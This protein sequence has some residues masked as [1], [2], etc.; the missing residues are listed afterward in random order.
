MI[1][2]L[3]LFT[4]CTF[5]HLHHGPKEDKTQQNKQVHFIIIIWY[6]NSTQDKSVRSDYNGGKNGELDDGPSLSSMFYDKHVVTKLIYAVHKLGQSC[7]HGSTTKSL[8]VQCS[9]YKTVYKCSKRGLVR[10]FVISLLF[11]S[12]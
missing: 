2:I 8:I 1:W 4:R 6:L 12:R 11:S 7:T 10:R 5:S 3:R 9:F